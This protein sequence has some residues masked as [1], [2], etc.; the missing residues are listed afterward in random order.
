MTEMTM[1]DLSAVD[2]A[3]LVTALEDHSD[4]T[5]WWI[6]GGTGEVWMWSPD[7]GPDPEFDPETRDGARPIWPLESGIAYGDMEDFIASVPDQRAADL[8]DRAI[9]GRGAFRRFKDT[10]F[11]FPELRQ[12]WFR[13][14]DTRMRRRAIEFLVDEDL[15]D[16]EEANRALAELDD[17]PVG[18]GP[19]NP[20]RVA[21]AV[22][23]DLRA[24]Y[25]DRLV[26]VVLYGSQARSDAHP[27][28]DVDLAV[29]LD[30]M[31]SPWDE[32]RLMDEVL[33]RRT[34]ESGVT[35]SATPL[36]RE[37]W[38]HPRRPLVRTAKAE[39][40]RLA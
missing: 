39:G 3:D 16:E 14:S 1:L 28:S 21:E 4:E 37:A 24:L 23:A 7:L 12:A 34:L 17:P 22:A 20:R 30:D 9:A 31:A 27:E 36:S 33:W 11:E 38:E 15:V 32:L 6:D 40:E 5:S 13:F 19:V 29:I 10:L 26:T 35:V 2:L 25:G 18:N 8:L